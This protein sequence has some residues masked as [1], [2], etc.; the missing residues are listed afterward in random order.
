MKKLMISML[1]VA[2]A[3]CATAC[4]DDDDEENMKASDVASVYKGTEII[5]ET[6]VE[7]ADEEETTYELAANANTAKINVYT[8][9]RN[10]MVLD[11]TGTETF[12]GSVEISGYPVDVKGTVKKKNLT[13]KLTM[14]ND[15]EKSGIMMTKEFTGKKNN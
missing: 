11:I 2:M 15:S 13:L 3:F 12:G 14:Y 8:A 1:A 5:K 10:E 6:G 4:N 7:E 9:N